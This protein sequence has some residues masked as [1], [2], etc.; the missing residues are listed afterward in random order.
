MGS[1]SYDFGDRLNRVPSACRWWRDAVQQVFQAH[2]KQYF[3]R[4]TSARPFG[5]LAGDA[6][7]AELLRAL[8]QLGLAPEKPAEGKP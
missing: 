3:I 7:W 1:H 5:E 2:Q 8:A 4:L 6:D